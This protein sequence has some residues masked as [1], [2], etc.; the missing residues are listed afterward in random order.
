VTGPYMHDGR[1]T[2]LTQVIEHYNSGVQAHPNLDVRLRTSP[3]GPVTPRRLGLT[4][5]E[6]QSIAA[7]LGTL[8][9]EAL[10]K[11]PVFSDPFRAPT[12][13]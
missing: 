2:T 6:V 5:A 1:F 3:T 13:R 10:L 7:F 11:D 4:A 8:T 9:D 12:R